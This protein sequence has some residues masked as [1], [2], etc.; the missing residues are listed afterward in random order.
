MNQCSDSRQ[1]QLADKERSSQRFALFVMT[2][3]GVLAVLSFIRGFGA[4]VEEKWM[5]MTLFFLG[6][7]LSV[8]FAMT[9]LVAMRLHVCFRRWERRFLS[10]ES[11]VGGIRQIAG[12]LLLIWMVLSVPAYMF[13]SI[14]A[15]WHGEAFRLGV[16]SFA[17]AATA[18]VCMTG[19]ITLGIGLRA[20][21]LDD[22]LDAKKEQGQ[23]GARI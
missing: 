10:G 3:L 19:V 14:I 1:E 8:I 6:S 15:A 12:H 18:I 16:Y 13:L 7:G 5:E 17:C 11:P 9:G 2:L 22:L 20:R 4:G 23:T 21:R